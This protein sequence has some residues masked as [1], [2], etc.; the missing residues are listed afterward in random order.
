[1]TAYNLKILQMLTAFHSDNRIHPSTF[2]LIKDNPRFVIERNIKLNDKL[3]ETGL[4]NVSSS[5]AWIVTKNRSVQRDNM[6]YVTDAVNITI[7]P[8]Y[9]PTFAPSRA[10]ARKLQGRGF[11]AARDRLDSRDRCMWVLHLYF[12]WSYIRESHVG[13]R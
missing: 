4:G 13:H 3:T 12:A 1:M 6:L 9:Y 11:I 5:S 7:Y 8:T 10:C 2:T